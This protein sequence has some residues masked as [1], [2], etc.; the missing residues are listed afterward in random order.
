[1]LEFKNAKQMK[2]SEFLSPIRSCLAR[3]GWIFSRNLTVVLFNTE[4]MTQCAKQELNSRSINLLLSPNSKKKAVSSPTFWFFHDL[5]PR[6]RA[7]VCFF[8]PRIEWGV[9]ITP[10]PLATEKKDEAS[11][12]HTLMGLCFSRNSNEAAQTDV[13][14]WGWRIILIFS[15]NKMQQSLM[16]HLCLF[17]LTQAEV[18][19]VCVCLCVCPRGVATKKKNGMAKASWLV[20]ED[21]HLHNSVWTNIL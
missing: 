18:R 19:A 1:M 5:W 8:V 16:K 15:C 13:W 20:H 21:W 17:A 3:G 4:L 12:T 9:K 10:F 14:W 2:A 7:E 6:V 11:L